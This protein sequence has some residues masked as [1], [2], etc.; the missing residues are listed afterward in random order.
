MFIHTCLCEVL[1]KFGFPV[2]GDK[3][4]NREVVGGTERGRGE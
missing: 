2:S 3:W 4:V 1:A